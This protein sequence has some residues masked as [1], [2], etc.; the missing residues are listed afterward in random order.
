MSQHRKH[1]QLYCMDSCRLFNARGGAQ[2]CRGH[3]APG[4]AVPSE[5]AA[6]VW[7]RGERYALTDDLK[8]ALDALAALHLM[9]CL[10]AFAASMKEAVRH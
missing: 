1:E 6:T 7:L 8:N 3:D 5:N 9:I 10:V 4:R 2:P